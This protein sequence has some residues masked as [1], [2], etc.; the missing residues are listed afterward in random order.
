MKHE[1]DQ[2]KKSK[3]HKKHNKREYDSD[4]DGSAEAARIEQ[5]KLFADLKTRSADEIKQH[6]VQTAMDG[7]PEKM[8]SPGVIHHRQK[9]LL[10]IIMYLCYA[11]EVM[12]LV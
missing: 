7:S 2:Y 12:F 5:Q 4:D 8:G 6:A 9:L 1:N 3:K 10:I 11:C